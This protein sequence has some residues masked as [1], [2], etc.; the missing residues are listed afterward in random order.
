[1]QYL[2]I[3][4]H[5]ITALDCI[6]FNKC[7]SQQVKFFFKR[8][9]IN[10]G[11]RFAFFSYF[12]KTEKA[13]VVKLLMNSLWPSDI[14]WWHRSGSMLVQVPDSTKPLAQVMAWCQQA[15]SHHL[16]QCQL[17]I[18]EILWHSPE[19][20]FTAIARSTILY[21]KFENYTF[22]IAATSHRG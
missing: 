13:Q 4:D 2:T 3:L 9:I 14:T 17:H 18:S 8:Y 19:S 5:V 16:S 1:M 15:R 20:I 11:S 7:D 22:H 21:D 10:T 6:L 12:L